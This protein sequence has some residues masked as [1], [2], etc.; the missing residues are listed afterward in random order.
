MPKRQ[1]PMKYRLIALLPFLLFMSSCID[2]SDSDEEKLKEGLSELLLKLRGANLVEEVD[3]D[4]LPQNCA[5]FYLPS[6]GSKAGSCITPMSVS[7]NVV[8]VNLAGNYFGG[9]IRLLGGG[10]GL[11]QSFAIEGSEFN[12]ENP[13]ALGGEDNAQDT[14]FSELNNRIETKFN[15]LDIKFA[16]PR[17][18][19]NAFWTIKYVFV[20]NPFTDTATYTAGN[21]DGEFTATGETVADCIEDAYPDAVQDAIDNNANLLGGL[22]DA[23]AGD[24]LICRKDFS[25]LECSDSDFEWLNTATN[26]FI[27]TRPAASD[28]Y[29][30]DSLADHKVTC[31]PQDQGYHVDLGGFNVVADLYS[32]VMFSAEVEQSSKI[33]EFQQ[34]GVSSSYQSGSEI[35]MLIDF[36]VS[37]SLFIYSEDDDF[38]LDSTPDYSDIKD[39]SDGELAKAIWFKPVMV[40]QY[41]DC[42]PWAPGNCQTVNGS[43]VRSGI[44]ANINVTLKGETEHSVFVCEDSA[45][46]TSSCL[47]NE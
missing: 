28:V 13:E 3:P 21:V 41:S 25:I 17:E 16:L 47:G 8:S 34:A 10:S 15:Y 26:Q 1:V 39:V 18:D 36:D 2:L 31:E 33:Y 35:S 45:E 46:D 22:Q 27:A 14:A 37:K 32:E 9:G 30:F 6:G 29:K 38:S 4:L 12:M 19:G 20:D 11:G 40:W 5:N 44:K 42:T 43:Q 24:I 23:K 7:G